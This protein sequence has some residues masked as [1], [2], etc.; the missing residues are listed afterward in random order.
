MTVSLALVVLTL[1]FQAASIKP[2]D[3]DRLTGDQ[4]TGTL[5]YVDY[6]SG[7]R[8]PIPSTLRVKRADGDAAAWLFEYGYPKE[9]QANG[10]KTAKLSADGSTF[11]DEK[12]VE[13]AETP[14]GLKLV[15][16]K[17]G[18]DN[19]KPALFRYT[20]LVGERSLSIR[21]EVRYDGAAEFFERNEYRWSR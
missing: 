3:L 16:E 6:Q 18:T 4:W 19:N 13:R 1:A 2:A 5:T 7:K 11:D 15:T 12:V 17:P 8:T 14:A 20:W 10:A 9:P 21:K